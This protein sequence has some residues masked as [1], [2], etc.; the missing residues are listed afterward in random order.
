MREFGAV[1]LGAGGVGKSALACRF[2]QDQFLEGYDPTIEEAHRKVWSVDGE[3]VQLDVLD[4]AGAEQFTAI[5]ELYIQNASGFVLIFS[6]TQ[7]ASLRDVESLRQ[8]ICRVKGMEEKDIPVIVVGT[9]S[10]LI[11][12]REVQRST[13]QQLGSS[14]KIPIYETSSKKNLHVQEA[15]EDLVRQMRK[16]IPLPKERKRNKRRISCRIM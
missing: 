4:T 5:T 12:E 7:E 1:L 13:I 15:F 16:K 3:M 6:L 8:Q 11:H 9:K 10:D 2:I 14:W